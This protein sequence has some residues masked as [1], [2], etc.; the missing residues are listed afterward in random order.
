MPH[1]VFRCGPC[2]KDFETFR[3]KP[4]AAR[5]AKCPTC[6]L[7]GQRKF[8]GVRV[9]AAMDFGGYW[10]EAMGVGDEQ[11]R[12]PGEKYNGGNDLW[13]GGKDDRKRLMAKL[14]YHD[15]N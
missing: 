14:D 12:L 13:V 10:S 2:G 8:D 1:Y 15:S 3:R 7:P 5:K 11:D 9:K 6:R 4:V